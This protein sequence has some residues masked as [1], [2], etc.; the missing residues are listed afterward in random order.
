MRGDWK[1]CPGT[2]EDWREG[3]KGGGEVDAMVNGRGCFGT[4]V[5]GEDVFTWP[6]SLPRKAGGGESR[7]SCF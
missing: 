2:R 7:Q 4:N 3:G 6:A 1:L 5:E